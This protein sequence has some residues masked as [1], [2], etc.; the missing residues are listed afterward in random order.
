MTER[1]TEISKKVCELYSQYGIRSVTMDDV[2]SELGISKKTLYQYFKDKTDLVRAAM[3]YDFEAKKNE[4][5]NCHDKQINAVEELINFSIVQLKMVT[6]H[7]P[8]LLYDLSKYYP[9]ISIEFQTKKREQMLK[10]L[11]TNLKRGK[12]EGLYR[13]DIDEN[14]I[15]KLNLVRVEGMMNSKIFKIE[16]LMSKEFFKEAF[17]YHA[18]GIVSDKGRI[19]LE[20]NL[21]KLK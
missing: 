7:S 3:D 8:T 9:E 11:L 12:A 5:L 18:Y 2:V 19:I 6:S 17:T 21:D 15:A 20:Q 16:E 4:Y 13:K 1:K 14:L 10:G